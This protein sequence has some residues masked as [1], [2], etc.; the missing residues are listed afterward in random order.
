MY[1]IAYE[2]DDGMIRFYTGKEHGTVY[3]TCGVGAIKRAV[4]YK[5]F[6]GAERVMNELRKR[7]GG[8]KARLFI[9]PEEVYEAYEEWD[10]RRAAKLRKELG[11]E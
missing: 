2:P 1:V 6:S 9:M 5:T 11:I 4:K 7:P 10:H 3:F 8:K